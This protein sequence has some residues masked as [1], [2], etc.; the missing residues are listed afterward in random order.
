LSEQA[1]SNYTDY[2]AQLDVG[3]SHA[4][5]ATARPC[6]SSVIEADDDWRVRRNLR[7]QQAW[8]ASEFGVHSVPGTGARHSIAGANVVTPSP[9]AITVPALL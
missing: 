5:K 9:T 1:K 7:E 6:C 4:C 8:D 2:V 3:D